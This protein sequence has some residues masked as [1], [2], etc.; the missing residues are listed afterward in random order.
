M[1]EKRLVSGCLLVSLS[2]ELMQL[3]KL[4]LV[5]LIA[6]CVV[7]PVKATKTI[8]WV[9]WCKAVDSE[10]AGTE[11]AGYA[12]ACGAYFAGVVEQIV[13]TNRLEPNSETIP[14]LPENFT[15]EQLRLMFLKFAEENPETLHHHQIGLING[16][17]F[18]EF[19]S[20]KNPR[21]H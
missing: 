16:M 11:N 1:L 7:S 10:W 19:G 13:I 21:V 14:C 4:G 20:C 5:V 18:G 12:W 9:E 3:N 2:S 6:I 17:L 8:T 15:S